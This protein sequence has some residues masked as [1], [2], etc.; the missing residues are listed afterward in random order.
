[1][2]AFPFSILAS[3][4]SYSLA[5][6]CCEASADDE[7]LEIYIPL[8]GRP[9]LPCKTLKD[10]FSKYESKKLFPSINAIFLATLLLPPSARIARENVLFEFKMAGVSTLTSLVE[11]LA[12]EVKIAGASTM[13]SSVEILVER[14]KM[15]GVSDLTLLVET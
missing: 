14:V 7:D 4:L 2:T 6:L 1:M 9:L 10:V 15:S 11:T 12:E 13:T 3:L 5:E 8:G